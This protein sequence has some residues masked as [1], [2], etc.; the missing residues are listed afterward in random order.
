MKNEVKQKMFKN[1]LVSD[2]LLL[3]LL[4]QEH[5]LIRTE[6]IPRG[7]LCFSCRDRNVKNNLK[8]HGKIK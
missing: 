6:G 1:A 7:N 2:D 8:S 3:D 4:E 5:K